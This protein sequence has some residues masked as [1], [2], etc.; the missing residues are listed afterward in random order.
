MQFVLNLPFLL[1]VM[2]VCFYGNGAFLSLYIGKLFRGLGW[3]GVF[4]VFGDNAL[5]EGEL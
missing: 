2:G 3:V 1:I 4:F 5:L